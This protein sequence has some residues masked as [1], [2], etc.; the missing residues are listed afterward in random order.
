M[1]DDSADSSMHHNHRS[2]LRSVRLPLLSKRRGTYIVAAYLFIKVLYLLNAIGQIF[3]MQRFLGFNS[4]T[5]SAFGLTV[6]DNIVHGHDWQMTQIFPRVGFCYAEMKILGVRTNGVT[7]QCALP[8]N[9]LNE[10]LYIFLW[11]WIMFAAII[12]AAYLLLWIVRFCTRSREADYIIKY[13]RLTDDVTPYD[14]RDANDFALRFL[15]HDGMFLIRMVRMNAGDVVAAAVVNEL[16]D[17]YQQRLRE[18]THNPFSNYMIPAAGWSTDLEK[19]GDDTA[20]RNRGGAAAGE[21]PS[22]PSKEPV[23]E[24]LYPPVAPEPPRSIV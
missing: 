8:V 1:L 9:M 7:A 10:K 3:M 12:T 16:W 15:R 20:V 19:G 5:S 24:S 4:T 6:L 21:M 18:K 14:E 17:R 23:K 2:A 13:I 11:W 22:A